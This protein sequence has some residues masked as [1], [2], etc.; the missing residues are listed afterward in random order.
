[1]RKNAVQGGGN[2]SAAAAGAGAGA[3]AEAEG[4]LTEAEKIQMSTTIVLSSCDTLMQCR[5]MS[6]R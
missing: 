5:Y 2:E 3:E 1:M 4:S 6:Y